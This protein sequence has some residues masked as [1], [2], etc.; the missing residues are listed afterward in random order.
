VVSGPRGMIR[1]LAITRTAGPKKEKRRRKKNDLEMID[2]LLNYNTMEGGD[3]VKNKAR[4]AH[5]NNRNLCI[6][7][8]RGKREGQAQATVQ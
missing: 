4:D 3:E 7:N 6:L 8:R 5:C 1:S 2:A